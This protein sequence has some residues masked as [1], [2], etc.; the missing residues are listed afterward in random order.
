M[1]PATRLDRVDQADQVDQ[2]RRVVT[3]LELAAE[4]AAPA[5]APLAEALAL[6]LKIMAETSMLLFSVADLRQHDERIADGVRTVAE[7]LLAPARSDAVL[8]AIC[9]DPGLARDHAVAHTVLGHLGYPDPE[10]DHLLG[11]SLALG[12]DFG[13]ERLPHRE[14]EQHWLER[15]RPGHPMEDD[16]SRHRREA[17]TLARSS[18]GRPMDALGSTVLDN[19]AFTHAVLYASDFGTRPVRLDRPARS[20]SADA[21]TG[22]AAAL[23][24]DHFDLTA[25]LLWTWPML[26][27]GPTPASGFASRLLSSVQKQD[28]FSY[29]TTFVL[30]FLAAATLRS[31]GAEAVAPGPPGSPGALADALALL[32]SGP[33]PRW[34]A[35]ARSLDP[36]QDADRLAP[37]ALTVVYRRGRARADLSLVKAGL[38]VALRHDLLDGP[39]PVQALALLRRGTALERRRADQRA[40]RRAG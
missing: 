11:E 15:I 31:E 19:Y 4:L 13:P 38:E 10:V 16:E 37:L 33:E 2:V 20:I 34:L 7:R 9:L 8:A 24:G 12:T 5:P 3:A 21:E 26:R 6:Q 28:E 14:L 30:G 32:D 29:H 40:D 36:D 39:A 25:E 1:P 18:L 35:A 27:L 17:T 22:L 23:D